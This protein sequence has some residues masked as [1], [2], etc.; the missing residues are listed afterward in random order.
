MFPFPYGKSG[1]R[2]EFV[3]RSSIV[4]SVCTLVLA[5]SGFGSV[6]SFVAGEFEGRDCEYYRVDGN[7]LIYG[8]S[9]PLNSS[10]PIHMVARNLTT[11]DETELEGD[12]YGTS[13]DLEDGILVYAKR[14]GDGDADL[15]VY[16]L[17]AGTSRSFYVGQLSGL[18]VSES[19]VV[20]GTKGAR[21]SRVIA[22]S[23]THDGAVRLIE[24]AGRPKSASDSTA[25]VSRDYVVFYRQDLSTRVYSVMVQ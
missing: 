23:S 18:Y 20:W 1:L 11:G 8:C 5:G 12:W 7:W 14:V 19:T 10:R 17:E 21:D 24:D 4:L 16:D 25:H 15:L 22:I 3:V 13:I 2:E 6:P 9:P